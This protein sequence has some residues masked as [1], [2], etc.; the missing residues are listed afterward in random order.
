M[1]RSRIR[2]AAL[3][4]AFALAA[5]PA[6]GW[7]DALG[8]DVGVGIGPILQ[9]APLPSTYP[10]DAGRARDVDVSGTRWAAGGRIFV[11]SSPGPRI[12]GE[13]AGGMGTGWRLGYGGFLGEYLAPI[14]PLTA[15]AGGGVGGGGLR[16]G[17]GI[18]RTSI[19]FLYLQPRVGL[20]AANEVLS[21]EVHLF[22][23][24]PFAVAEWVDDQPAT[25]GGFYGFAGVGLAMHLQ[26]GP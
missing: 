5:A 9:L 15:V 10:M 23:M 4:A 12:G 11:F 6:V 24:V 7:A 26:R 20:M 17:S 2:H 22:C 19:R 18:H 25:V 8:E 16:V 3:A 13:G 21:V 1:V 14:G